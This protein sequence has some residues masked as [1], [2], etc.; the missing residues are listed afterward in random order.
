MLIHQRTTSKFQSNLPA[1]VL[2]LGGRADLGFAA[3]DGLAVGGLAVDREKEF[4][5]AS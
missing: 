4:A 2:H 1:E 5:E 3:E